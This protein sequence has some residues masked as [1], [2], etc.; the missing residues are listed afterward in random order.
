ML[1]FIRARIKRKLPNGRTALEKWSTE[2]IK[3]SGVPDNNST[4]FAVAVMLMHQAEGETKQSLKYFADRL[5]KASINEVAHAIAQEL[6]QKQKEEAE[7][8]SKKTDEAAKQA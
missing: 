8:A 5:Y 4:R 1:R 2:V 3:L 6:K 7:A